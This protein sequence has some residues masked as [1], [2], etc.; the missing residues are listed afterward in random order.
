M[1]A[2]HGFAG[3]APADAR[4]QSF[5]VCSIDGAGLKFSARTPIKRTEP[6]GGRLKRVWRSGGERMATV[7]EYNPDTA[8]VVLAAEARLSSITVL[9]AALQSARDAAGPLQL[10]ASRVERTDA[11]T[12]QLLYMFAQDCRHRQ[13]AWQWTAASDAFRHAVHLLGMAEAL[14]LL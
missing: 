12:L 3:H 5:G 14:A 4:R 2:I 8:C 7:H 10:D 1:P 13:V 6:S 9:Q 11:A